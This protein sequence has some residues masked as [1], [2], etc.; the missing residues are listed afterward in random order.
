[1]NWKDQLG[2][3]ERVDGLIRRK[4]TGPPKRLAHKLGMS[5][6]SVYRLIARM[7]EMELPIYYCRQTESYTYE[8][9]V[10]IEFEIRVGIE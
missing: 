3:I 5:E 10:K 1:M 6:R 7:R 9:A 4:Q 2:N 8:Q